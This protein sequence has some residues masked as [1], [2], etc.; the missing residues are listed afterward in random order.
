MIQRN[1]RPGAGGNINIR[2][3]GS[4]GAAPSALILVDGIPTGSFNDIDPNDVENISVLKDAASASI[5]GSRAANGVMLI[6][7]K[8]GITRKGIGVDVSQTVQFEH[9]YRAPIALQ[10]VYGAGTTGFFNKDAEGRDVV[11]WSGN[12]FGPKMEGQMAKL[13]NGEFAPYS[14]MPDN[15]MYAYQ[16]G[17]YFNTNVAVEGGTDKANFRFSY[18]RLD[19][20]SVEPNNKF[21]R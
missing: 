12:S 16:T 2:G 14:P 3:I 6:T 17:K 15:Q 7:T 8:K 5:Y 9:A 20:N 1:G 13:P 10:N 4:F 18:S 11:Q 21:S 19:N